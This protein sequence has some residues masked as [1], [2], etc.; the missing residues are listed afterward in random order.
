MAVTIKDVAKA[1]GVSPSTVSRTINNHYSI[2]EETKAR[3]RQVMKELGYHSDKMNKVVRTIGVVF[4][5]SVVDAY[6]NPIYLEIIRGISYICNK[7]HYRLEII[8][9]A[10][11][12]EMTEG[13]ITAQADGYIFLYSNIDE[14]VITHLTEKEIPFIM[15][16]KPMDK[17]TTTLSVDTDNVQAGYEAVK[18]LTEL[19][20]TK[21]G[22]IGTERKGQFSLDRQIG[23]LQCITEKRFPIRMDYI[24]N[25]SSSYSYNPTA[26]LEL[27]K[28][29][30]RP[31]AFV[32]CD[33]I[34]AVIMVRLIEEAGLRCP[35]DISLIS[36]NNSIF[37]RLMHPE[38][39]SF[40]INANQLGMEAVS[41]LIKHIET[42]TMFTTRTIVPFTLVKRRSCRRMEKA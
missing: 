6:E 30:D 2:S 39:T 35:E 17:S 28:R 24:L 4:Q 23:Y 25:I 29:D 38:L 26:I 20:H 11:Y 36:F 37:A 19:G 21:I 32:V 22:Y 34:Y 16:G 9:G 33:D 40:D 13:I 7:S 5:R 8:T 31:T 15:V 12:S 27:L 14:R 3:V 42:P 10:D 41:Q 1:A 18:Y